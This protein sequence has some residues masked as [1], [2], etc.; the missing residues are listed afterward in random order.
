VKGNAE[1]AE[2]WT[3]DVRTYQWRFINASYGSWGGSSVPSPLI[4]PRE[5]HVAETVRGNVYVFGGRRHDEETGLVNFLDDIWR[6]NIEQPTWARIDGRL[7]RTQLNDDQFNN[8]GFG[9]E[10]PR[11]RRAVFRADG[12]QALRGH[13]DDSKSGIG[14]SEMCVTELVLKVG[15]H[16]IYRLF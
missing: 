11:G 4:T 1:V 15:N 16:C 6:L 8:T 13:T 14:T 10:L 12:T 9:A 2:V 7:S 5:Q 3:W